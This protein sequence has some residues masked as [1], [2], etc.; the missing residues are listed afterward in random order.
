METERRR[1][2]NRVLSPSRFVAKHWTENSVHVYAIVWTMKRD[3]RDNRLLGYIPQRR[4]CIDPSSIQR[5]C[6][7]AWMY[8]QT[9]CFFP[10]SKLDVLIDC[11]R[12]WIVGSYVICPR[13]PHIKIVKTLACMTSIAF[14]KTVPTRGSTSEIILKHDRGQGDADCFNKCCAG[15]ACFIVLWF[16]RPYR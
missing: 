10:A 8:L 7:L 9:I 16:F 15:C 4:R 6:M 13:T 12:R 11:C 5:R 3:G 14:R 1:E 2:I